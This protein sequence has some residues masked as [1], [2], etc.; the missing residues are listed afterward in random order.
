M[1]LP[2]PGTI[3]TYSNGEY[4][5]PGIV[6][7]TADT[8]VPYLLSDCGIPQPGDGTAVVMIWD[9][10]QGSCTVSATEGTGAGQITPVTA[11]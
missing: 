10:F 2:A 3:V 6:L 8:W 1:T 7:L 4:T 11:T 5:S 9:V